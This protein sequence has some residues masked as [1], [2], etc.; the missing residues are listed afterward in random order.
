MKRSKDDGEEA[1][2][3]KR[4][5]IQAEALD[6]ALV[7]VQTVAQDSGPLSTPQSTQVKINSRVVNKTLEREVALLH[8]LI[9]E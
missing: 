4:K 8:V 2:H 9:K 1:P 6:L 7:G 5:K 3:A